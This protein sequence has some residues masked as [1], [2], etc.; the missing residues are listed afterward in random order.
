MQNAIFCTSKQQHA[1]KITA[2]SLQNREPHFKKSPPSPAQKL[3]PT[4]NNRLQCNHNANE[5]Q[6]H[7]TTLR[8]PPKSSKSSQQHCPQLTEPNTHNN[9]NPHSTQKQTPKCARNAPHSTYK[10][11]H[12]TPK[13]A[14]QTI[15]LRHSN[16]SCVAITTTTP[17]DDQSDETQSASPF[18]FLDVV[19]TLS[20]ACLDRLPTASHPQCVLPS[21][22][23][24]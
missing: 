5:P 24:S 3:I 12:N 4:H 7:D 21:S 18:A 6:K 9:F 19:S 10:L 15:F 20:A 2:I 23:R 11:I 16:L 14:T 17:T 22:G 1:R 13:I 8:K